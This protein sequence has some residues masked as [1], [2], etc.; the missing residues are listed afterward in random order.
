MARSAVSSDIHRAAAQGFA[1]H[2]EAYARGRPDYPPQAIDW[3]RDDLALAPGKTVLDLGAGTGKFLSTLRKTGATMIAVEPV[4]AMR[5]QLLAKNPDVAALEG[6]AEAISLPDASLDAV[7]CAQAFH[8]FATPRALSEIRRALK[9]GGML[10]LI[11]NAR[12]ESV[13]WVRAITDIITPYEGD[14]PRYYTGKWRDVFPADGFGPLAER[15]FPWVHTGAPERV[16]VDR[17]L[18]SSFI[19][20][21]PAEEHAAVAARLRALIAATPSLAG[22]ATVSY[23]YVTEAFAA[24][25]LG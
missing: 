12:D 24:R 19:A 14:A 11:W 8:W 6:A 16:I 15:R 22:K 25:K 5:A 21:L 23:P 17:T 13:G 10:G 20:A 2:A 7:V 3:L 4:A 1:A 9:P 18:S